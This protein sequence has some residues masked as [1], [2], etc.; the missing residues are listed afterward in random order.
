L[1][2]VC[3]LAHAVQSERAERLIL[4]SVSGGG[5]SAAEAQDRLALF[6]ESL[7]RELPGSPHDELVARIRRQ[8]EQE[9]A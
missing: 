2:D 4:A 1:R 7:A 9:V 3:D 6:E 5:L 8:V